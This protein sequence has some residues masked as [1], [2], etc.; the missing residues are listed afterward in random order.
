MSKNFRNN[1]HQKSTQNTASIAFQQAL[2]FHQR[3]ELTKAQS[4]YEKILKKQPKHFDSLHLLGVLLCQTDHHQRAFDLLDKAIKLNPNNAALYLNRGNALYNLKQF[5]DAL[6]NYD[7]A[8]LLK[9]DYA[10][11]YSNRGDVLQHLKQFSIAIASYDKAIQFEAGLAETHYSRGNSLIHLNQF[12]AAIVSYDKAIQLKPDFAEAYSNHGNALK[13]SWKFDAAITSYNKAIQLKS[14]FAEA[15]FNRGGALSE[16]SK[17]DD[18]CASYDKAFQL[19]PDIEYLFGTLLQTRKN[20]C[21]WDNL[22]SDVA[23]LIK[24]IDLGIK[25]SPCFTILNLTTSLSLQRKASEIWI[26]DKYPYNPSLGQ[27]TKLQRSNKIRI[28]YFSADFREHPVSYSIVELFEM[29]D[30]SK[31]ELVAFSFGPNTNDAMMKRVMLAFDEFIDVTTKTDSEIATLARSIKIDIAIDLSGLTANNRIGIFSY[32]AA[33]IQVSYMGYPGTSGASYIDYYIGDKTVIPKESRQY[34]SEKIVY[35]PNSAIIKDRKRM[36][37]DKKFTREEVGLPTEGFIFCCFNTNYKIT[38]DVFDSWTKIL[39]AVKGSVLWLLAGNLTAAKNLR[40]EAEKRG[41]DPARLVFAK[42]MQLP[43]YL[44][45]YQI[46]DLFIDTLAYTGATTT[47]DALWAGLPVVTCAGE[48]FVN[49]MSA[50]LLIAINLPELITYTRSEYEALAIDLATNPVKLRFIKDKL[51][52]NR[53]TTPLFDTPLFTR[54]IE[55]AYTEMFE[56]YQAD[57]LPDHIEIKH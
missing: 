2:V 49:R 4:L 30:R 34:Y 50:S 52:A 56:R 33:P 22:E 32:R 54:H 46:S 16:L 15:Y 19:D 12:D 45:S 47:S 31:F 35:L 38:P 5:S 9:S 3:G 44:A 11:A 57:L 37:S 41:L 18:A 48:S 14:D 20:L 40:K 36:I 1:S 26:S 17:L 43:E 24:K 28:G 10:E 21:D 6:E 39:N 7:K 23:E 42:K 29:H 55:D 27:I 53:L 25:A 8:I 13:D 51:I